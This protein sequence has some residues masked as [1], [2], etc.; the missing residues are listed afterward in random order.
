VSWRRTLVLAGIGALFLAG[1]PSSAS[2]DACEGEDTSITGA[3]TGA[4][5]EVMLCLVNVHRAA[6]GLSALTMDPALQ[7]ASR[8]HSRWMDSND[9]LCHTPDNPTPGGTCD[10]TP[11]SR[12]RA[13]GYPYSAGENILWTNF[14]GYTPREVFELWHGSPGHDA[15]MLYEHY[16]TAGMGIVTGAHGVTGTQ[17]FGTQSNGATDS[18]VDLLRKDGCPAAQSEVTADQAA[19]A[20]AERR[21]K[22]AKDRKQERKWRNRLEKA[23]A[24]LAADQAVETAQCHLTSYE[25]S[26][27]SPP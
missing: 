14:P 21:V 27:L 13:A 9:N 17:M 11:D 18:A 25:G 8:D 23:R 1:P 7:T 19:V 10:G 2:A 22:H 3:T 20:K 4:A 5:D 15:N 6:N 12:A 26:A 24:E 16:E